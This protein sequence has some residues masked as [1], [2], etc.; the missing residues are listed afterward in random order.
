[1]S[2]TIDYWLES[3]DRIKLDE[4]IKRYFDRFPSNA[5]G[6][7]ILSE[8]VTE[9]GYIKVTIRRDRSCD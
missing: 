7:Y 6:T 3:N 8:E 1:M 4:K 2:R 9:S 5:Y